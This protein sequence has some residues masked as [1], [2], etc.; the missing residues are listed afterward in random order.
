MTL[1]HVGPSFHYR[2]VKQDESLRTTTTAVIGIDGSEASRHALLWLLHRPSLADQIRPVATYTI[3]PVAAPYGMGVATPSVG[4]VYRESAEL[5]IDELVASIDDRRLMSK[6]VFESSAGPGLVAACEDANL[7]VVGSRGRS[8]LAEVL[9][10]SVSSY[11][12]KHAPIPVAVV[13]PTATIEG[14]LGRLVVGVDGSAN[15]QA[16]LHWALDNCRRWWHRRCSPLLSAGPVSTGGCSPGDR[17]AR[18]GGD[19]SSR[20]RPWPTW[21]RTRGVTV[22]RVVRLGDPRNFL[23]DLAAD[24]DLFVIGARGHRGVAYL[25]LGSVA[26]SLIHHPDVATVVVP[27]F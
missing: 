3:P 21:P 23:L 12:V 14:S 8:A 15:A 7:L 13:P 17:V 11:C 2:G 9:L 22:E 10:G 1:P 26:T 27:E 24:A 18:G 16:A 19:G 4:R 5:S 6:I 25:L 20:D